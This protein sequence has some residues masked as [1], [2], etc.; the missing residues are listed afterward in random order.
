MRKI[1]GDRRKTATKASTLDTG[2]AEFMLPRE[3]V[4]KVPWVISFEGFGV[5]WC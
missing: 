4:G 1:Y 3:V 5:H 2:G